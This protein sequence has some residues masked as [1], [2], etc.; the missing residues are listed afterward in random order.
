MG[1]RG[2]TFIGKSQTQSEEMIGLDSAYVFAVFARVWLAVC[3][4]VSLSL[5]LWF[6]EVGCEGIRTT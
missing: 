1:A 4:W 2:K 3:D 6:A 5:K